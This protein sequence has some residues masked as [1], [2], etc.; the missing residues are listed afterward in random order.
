LIEA[1]FMSERLPEY[2]VPAVYLHMGQWPLTPNRKLDR[3]A[4]A[5]E[6][7]ALAVA[8]YEPPQGPIECALAEIWQSL[9]SVERVGRHDN[10]FA[11]GG[12]S[13]LAVQFVNAARS[14]DLHLPV[15]VVLA[16]DSA[17]VAQH[18]PHSTSSQVWSTWA[19]VTTRW[20]SLGNH[21]T[22]LQPPHVAALAGWVQQRFAYAEALTNDAIAPRSA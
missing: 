2:K 6:A 20:C 7:D 4:S 14:R 9:L 18:E 15:N 11:V 19:P 3:K 13:L 10:F 21:V 12:H 8:V 5:P 1:N 17:D 22:L 16:I